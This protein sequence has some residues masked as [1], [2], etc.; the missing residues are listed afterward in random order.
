M[1]SVASTSPFIPLEWIAAHGLRPSTL[2]LRPASHVSVADSR[3]VC[4]YAGAWID[5]TLAEPDAA[6]VV[7]TTICDQMRYAAAILEQ[8]GRR[9]V[10][11][12]NVPSTWQTA[13]ARRLYRDELE[14]LGRFLVRLGGRSPT[15]DDLLRAMRE[16]DGARQ[17]SRHAPAPTTAVPLALVGGPLLDDDPIFDLIAQAGGRVVLDATEGGERT[18]PAPLDDDHAAQDPLD[19]LTRQYFDTIP[20]VFRRPNDPLFAWLGQ[21]L[22]ARSVRGILVRRYLWCDLW[23]AEVQRLREWSP[24]PVLEL[25]VGRDDESTRNRTQ[26]RLEAFLEMLR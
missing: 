9:P 12:F 10:F 22:A 2:P 20:D 25:D 4:P 3:G 17:G 16:Y 23:H 21:R 8:N 5:A 19:E 24:V 15:S 7:L 1:T 11:L 13:T 6:A 14:R 26:G 18:L